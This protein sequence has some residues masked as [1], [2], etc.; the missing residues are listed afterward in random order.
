MITIQSIFQTLFIEIKRY[1]ASPQKSLQNGLLTVQRSRLEKL[2]LKL[3]STT[4]HG[5][6][7]IAIQNNFQI[8]LSGN[9]ASLQFLKIVH[10]SNIH[11]NNNN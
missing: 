10:M 11:K 8:T 3:N 9:G 1:T 4:K 7:R 5:Y 6:F 2:K